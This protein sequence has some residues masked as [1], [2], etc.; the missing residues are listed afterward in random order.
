ML[1]SLG[2]WLATHQK[3]IRKL[4][5]FIILLYAAL[6]VTPAFLPL[7]G[8]AAKLWHNLTVFSQFLFWGIWWPFV[9]LSMVIFGRMWCG[10][11]CPEGSL[12]EFANKY[13]R[14]KAIPKWMMWRGWPF[15]TFS[16]T[17]IYGQ[18]TSV[19]Q[20]PKP[21]LL[22]LGGSTI[23]AIIIGLIYGKSSRIWCKY[24]C[25]VT[26]VFS[27]LAR[28][29]P[30]HFKPNKTKWKTFPIKQVAVVHC[31]TILPLRTM[32]GASACLMCG[33]CSGHREA[34]NLT[35]R[36]PNEE[37]VVH[38]EKNQNIWESMLIIFGLC[39][40]ALAAFQWSNSFWLNHFR[41]TIDTWFL[42]HNIMWVFN[43]DTPW[44]LF[45]HY[46]L[47]NDSFSWVFGA[48]VFSYIIVIGGF[49]AS[50]IALLI[51]LATKLSGNSGLKTFNHLSQ[52]LIPL[53]GC[54]VFIGLFANTITML[55]KYANLG[56]NSINA[57]K[58]GMLGLATLWSSVL[59]W[60]ILTQYAK[61]RTHKI[62]SMLCML[63]AFAVINYSWVLVLHIWTMKPDGIPWNTLW[64]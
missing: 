45:T 64:L 12:S 44:W 24:L 55:Q 36:S 21:A 14:G 47:Q 30:I 28:L 25:P 56:F 3:L 59:A 29:A 51:I 40:I 9:L 5:W 22:V 15:V 43:T 26:G 42:V 48:E 17:T 34:I 53:A 13:G 60:Q 33:K 4:Q 2:N 23:A 7:P 38:G 62:I 32:T 27:L 46:P 58:F 8:N 18:L 35:T 6:I 57:L 54:S 63:L 61:T 49:F 31:P 16:L 52:A 20:Y 50:L 41:D 10:I 39:G 19:Y 11:L 37:I 1:N